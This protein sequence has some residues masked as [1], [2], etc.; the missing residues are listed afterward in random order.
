MRSPVS[1][2]DVDPVACDAYVRWGASGYDVED[3]DEYYCDASH[4][5]AWVYNMMPCPGYL[6]EDDHVVETPT[7]CRPG[8]ICMDGTFCLGVPT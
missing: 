3:P 6:D 8:E 5:V 4:P 2:C 1:P 7:L